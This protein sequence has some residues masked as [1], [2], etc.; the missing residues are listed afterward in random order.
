MEGGAYMTSAEQVEWN[1]SHEVVAGAVDDRTA[2]LSDQRQL[3]TA[4][5]RTVHQHRLLQHTT[6]TA[7]TTTITTTTTATTI[8][9]ARHV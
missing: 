8:T 3:P 9:T 5:L 4:A 2:K 1:G 6:T 7:T